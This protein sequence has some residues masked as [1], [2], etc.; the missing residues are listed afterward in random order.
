MSRRIRSSHGG[1]HTPLMAC[2]HAVHSY[3]GG[4]PVIATMM[5]VNPETLRKK[6]DP[7]QDSH[8][9]ALDEAMHILNI[10]KDERVLDAI[11]AAVG[12]NWF[13]PLDAD[14]PPGD[15]DVLAASTS[16]MRSAVDVITELEKS[17]EDG[18]INANER[19]RIDQRLLELAR[20]M[21]R[22]DATSEQF[23][24]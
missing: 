24:S 11:T 10:T 21:K 23:E 5:A 22:L 20:Q 2:Y 12:A 6:L 9:L 15:L 18:D 13:W 8:R 17:L 16:L 1:L 3:P 14:Q 7:A 19:A 4:L